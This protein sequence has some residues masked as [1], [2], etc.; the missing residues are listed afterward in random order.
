[1]REVPDSDIVLFLIL[2]PLTKNNLLRVAKPINHQGNE[3]SFRSELVVVLVV[4]SLDT[5]E[6][7]Q[8]SWNS[9]ITTSFTIDKVVN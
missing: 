2:L 3:T 6:N 8:F 4:V 7:A 9:A 5:N 1:M